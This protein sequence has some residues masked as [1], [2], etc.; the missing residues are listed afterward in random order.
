[1]IVEVVCQLFGAVKALEILHTSTSMVSGF[2]LEQELLSS[3]FL[4]T[5]SVTQ[6]LVDCY[7]CYAFSSTME[8]YFNTNT[9]AIINTM[10]QIVDSQCTRVQ[11]T[12][13]LRESFGYPLIL[14][15]ILTV[16]WCLRQKV[17]H[18]KHLVLVAVTTAASLVT[19]QFSQFVFLTQAIA[20]L[21]LWFL[22][23]LPRPIITVIFLGKLV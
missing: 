20:L 23:P 18:W 16:S 7:L 15:Q 19:W 4:D 14:A 2:S 8:K 13:P 21:A 12:P 17:P 5:S 3:L 1:M 22:N 10:I 6:S 11:W 9:N